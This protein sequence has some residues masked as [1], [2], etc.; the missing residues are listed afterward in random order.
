MVV[1]LARELVRHASENP[2]GEESNVASFVCEWF[3]DRGIDTA[4]VEVPDPDRPSVAATVGDGSPR[5]VL[6]AHTDV[7]PAGDPA[8]WTFG[9]YAGRVDRGYLYGRGSTDTKASLAVA[10]TLASEL[11]DDLEAGE[12]AGTLVVHAPAGEETGYPGTRSLIEA[13]HGGDLAVVLEPTGFRVAT[14]AKGVATYR[15]DVGGRSAHASRPDDADNAID[16]LRSVL[17]RI[18]RYDARLRGRRNPLLGR[19][20]ATPTAVAAGLEGN[21]AVVPD[22]G[23]VLLDRRLLPDDSPSSVGAELDDLF[24]DFDV[25]RSLVQRYSAAAIRA[26]HPLASVLRRHASDVV[27]V[28][29]EPFGLE[30]ATDARSFVEVGTPAVIWGPGRLEQ[31][32]TVDER[33]PVSAIEDALTVL[34]GAVPEL[35]RRDW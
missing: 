33:I 7:V 14:S 35:L 24:R 29:T 17:D 30:A 20:F 16:E 21:M 18:E 28:S 4:L 26:D 1:D 12:L 5:V 23:H 9:P 6:N 13:G 8:E 34:R 11:R 32:H 27:G 22:A 19:A 25:E 10:M 31:A 3:D 15:L 2:P